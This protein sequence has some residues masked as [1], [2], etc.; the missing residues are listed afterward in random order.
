MFSGGRSISTYSPTNVCLWMA[1]AF[2]AG[3]LNTGGFIACHRFVSHV[4]G[5]ATFF[6]VEVSRAS[7]DHAAAALSVPFFFLCGTMVSAQLVDIPLRTEGRP[8]YDVV[9]GT[10]CILLSIVSIGG[11]YGLFGDFGRPLEQLHDHV[12]LALLC[13]ICGMQNGTITSVSSAVIRT[14]HL[15]GITTDLGIGLVRVFNRSRLQNSVKDDLRANFMRLGIILSFGFGAVCGALVFREV[16]YLGFMIPM[17]ISGLL[18]AVTLRRY[19][20]LLPKFGSI[21]APSSRSKS[22]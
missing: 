14:T 11:W 4:T 19:L 12:L 7:W 10:L 20:A 18:F 3:V 13:L 9:F 6:G 16:E 17:V 5:F 21:G 22:A 1:M 2:Q 15:T 8:R